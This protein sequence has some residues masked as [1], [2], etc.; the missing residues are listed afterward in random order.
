[1]LRSGGPRNFLLGEQCSAFDPTSLAL[2]PLSPGASCD[3]AYARDAHGTFGPCVP[4]ADGSCEFVHPCAFTSERRLLSPPPPPDEHPSDASVHGFGRAFQCTDLSHFDYDA[5]TRLDAA[6][7]RRDAHVGLAVIAATVRLANE[8]QDD[9]TQLL[10]AAPGAALR[11]CEHVYELV[12]ELPPTFAPCVLA[13][14]A[15]ACQAAEPVVCAA[16]AVEI[17]PVPAF[18]CAL[19]GGRRNSRDVGKFC[20]E[21]DASAVDCSGYYATSKNDATKTRLCEPDGTDGAAD[22]MCDA[23]EPAYCVQPPSSDPPPST[24]APP[25]PAERPNI[26][27]VL[28]DDVGFGDLPLYS[29]TA[30]VAMP[31][32]ASLARAGVS[33]SD[34]H[35]RTVCSPS[36]YALLSGNDPL[37]ARL[38]SSSWNLGRASFTPTQRT[39]ASVLRDA[40]WTT[41]VF[42]KWGVGAVAPEIDAAD[43]CLEDW[44]WDC[45]DAEND[46]RGYC[47]LRRLFCSAE[48]RLIGG[49]RTQGFDASFVS[50]AGIQAAPYAFFEDDVLVADG[51]LPTYWETGVVRGRR[52]TP[53]SLWE[54]FEEG[55]LVVIGE[56]K[57]ASFNPPRLAVPPALTRSLAPHFPSQVQSFKAPNDTAPLLNGVD[58][59]RTDQYDVLVLEKALA[60]I[61]GALTAARPFF[62]LVATAAVHVPHVPPLTLGGR[63]VRGEAVSAHADMLV[64]IDAVLGSLIHRLATRGALNDTITVFVSDN[65]GLSCREKTKE[66]WGRVGDLLTTSA[67]A[68]CSYSSSA[69]T[70]HPTLHPGLRGFKSGVFEGG[71][72]VPMVVSWPSGNLAPPPG[73]E[74]SDLV[75]IAD[76]Y[77]TLLDLAGVALPSGQALDA[78]SF[79]PLLRRRGDEG[80]PPPPPRRTL[81][82]FRPGQWSLRVDSWKLILDATG[83]RPRHCFDLSTD[84][85]ET[86]DRAAE[87]AAC[88]LGA[89]LLRAFRDAADGFRRRLGPVV[90]AHERLVEHCSPEI[91][92]EAVG[93]FVDWAAARAE[94]C[95][96]A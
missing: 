59:W 8:T 80:P 72:R 45:P 73:S 26:L 79:G 57:V 52:R 12:R 53:Q 50:V 96:A 6:G 71:H 5:T 31:A 70:G 75:T 74:L 68:G 82:L 54:P 84:V 3:S 21:L 77:P 13:V 32:V 55:S 43:P 38:G 35:A 20:R 22:G 18:D 36:R 2:P 33:F 19:R 24:S 30:P 61:D 11:A 76:L 89:P 64:A 51:G 86:R 1:M 69:A 85:S 17:E 23:S 67:A 62:A 14:D 92:E 63:P 78:V 34:A 95:E 91:F 47:Q 7:W 60:F 81:V 56:E 66:K 9:L 27:L 83:G 41:G 37:R 65:G 93:G 29:S 15:S 16:A 44:A 94:R 40:S 42:G 39:I 48:P 58:S 28:A 90:A 46:P 49:P 4:R 87:L 88:A 10:R 25:A